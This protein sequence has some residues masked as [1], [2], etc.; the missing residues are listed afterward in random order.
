MG[1]CL[2][3]HRPRRI[4]QFPACRTPATWIKSNALDEAVPRQVDQPYFDLDAYLDNGGLG[5]H[6]RGWRWQLLP[7]DLIYKSYLAGVKE[8]RSGTT[9]THIQNDGWLWEGVLGARIGLLRYGDRA[10]LFPQGFQIDAEGA[11]NVRLDVDDE[12][13]VAP[14]TIGWVYRSLTVLVP[15][16]RSSPTTI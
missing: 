15:S 13:D 5:I 2:W 6:E 12:V 8:P 7:N 3:R 10:C 1:R 14:R 11:A 9:V 16:R 4:P